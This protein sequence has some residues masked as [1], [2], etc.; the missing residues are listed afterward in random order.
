MTFYEGIF[1]FLRADWWL[2][3]TESAIGRILRTLAELFHN[4][5]EPSSK[6]PVCFEAIHARL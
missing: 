5:I 2:S 4:L 3:R 6:N 1:S